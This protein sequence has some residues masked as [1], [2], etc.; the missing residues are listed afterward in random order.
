MSSVKV[1][2]KVG[3]PKKD[4]TIPILLRVIAKRRAKYFSTGYSVKESQFRPG[5][6]NWVVKHPDS[7]LINAAIESKRAKLAETLYL[8]DINNQEIDVDD[9]GNKKPKGTF[10]SAIKSRMNTLEN[11]NQVASYNR[12]KAKLNILKTDGMK[13]VLLVDLNKQWVEKYISNRR[14]AGCKISTIKKDLTDFSSVLSSLDSYE[15]KDWF[16][17]AQ[18]KLKA[19]PVDRAKLT[20]K[21]IKA[22]ESAT[23]YGLD[24][25]ARDIF[26]FSFY[27]H[28]MRFQNV[29][30]FEKKMIKNGVLR[31]RMNKGQSIREIQVHAKLQGI[32]DKYNGKPYLFPVVK[33]LIT[34]NWK[35][36]Q[37]IDSA[38]SLLSPHIKRVAVV[39]GIEKN[40][41]M[42]VARHTFSY[43]SLERGVSMEI[44][45]D[46]LG[47]SDFKTTQM[48]L[49]S[50]S[51][52]QIN[53]S[54]K[55]L[56]D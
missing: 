26:L 18:G 28:G 7:V 32:I 6:E 4:G 23:L 14:S 20:L 38:A 39:C 50:L 37:L 3:Q 2:L 13:D 11:N 17:Q 22:M 36:K 19:A 30:M 53:E 52:T 44:L 1:V 35:K 40:V 49:K 15:G 16:K 54:V 46:A 31:Y 8:A 9:L 21:E 41:S 34:D 29:V 10:F 24:D 51:D 25:I 33:E 43:L 55:G 47:H 56:Y 48:Y 5:Q 42:H 45:K 27:C 12:L